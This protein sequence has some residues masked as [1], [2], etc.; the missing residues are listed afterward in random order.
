MFFLKNLGF[1]DLGLLLVGLKE[2]SLLELLLRFGL[3]FELGF[4]LILG[5][6]FLFLFGFLF[7]SVDRLEILFSV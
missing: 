2:F 6:R 3:E 4:L 7:S 5:K 1:C